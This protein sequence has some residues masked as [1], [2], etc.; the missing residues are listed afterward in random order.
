MAALERTVTNGSDGIGDRVF[1]RFP[2]R[3]E[4]DRGLI[5]GDFQKLSFLKV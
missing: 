1:A 2:W 3:A 5:Y 4:Q